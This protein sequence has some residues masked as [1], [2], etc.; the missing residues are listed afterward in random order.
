MA[1]LDRST[2]T[3][4]VLAIGTLVSYFFGQSKV[5]TTQQEVGVGAIAYTN[6]VIA[7]RDKEIEEL[8]ARVLL[9]EAKR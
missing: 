3:T 5:N 2:I 1:A 9:L 6:A 7:E 8:R 4:I